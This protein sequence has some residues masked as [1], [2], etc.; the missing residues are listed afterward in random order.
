MALPKKKGAK[1]KTALMNPKKAT[2]SSLEIRIQTVGNKIIAR[3]SKGNL[4]TTKIADP[5]GHKPNFFLEVRK[6]GIG[7]KEQF[8]KRYRKLLD[9]HDEL[10]STSTVREVMTAVIDEIKNKNIQLN[11]SE[12]N[13]LNLLF[14]EISR[15]RFPTHFS[16]YSLNGDHMQHPTVVNKAYFANPT[17]T[18]ARHSGLDLARKEAVVAAMEEAV[19]PNA[20]AADIAH[21]GIREAIAFTL[22]EFT[23]PITAS[24]VKPFSRV[25]N[26]HDSQL[27]DQVEAREQLKRTFRNLG[28]TVETGLP[29]INRPWAGRRREA[30]NGGQRLR[31][32]SPF[33]K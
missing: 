32:V 8:G 33:R 31:S 1:N 22:N 25:S 14:N 4:W 26:T 28:G 29:D 10:V 3:L 5:K 11:Q 12:I 21:A 15:V 20:T 9:K 6:S 27:M 23:A 17:N 30:Q 7:K 16:G 2:H 19:N 18:A 13:K 24:D